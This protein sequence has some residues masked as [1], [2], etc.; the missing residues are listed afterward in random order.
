MGVTFSLLRLIAWRRLKEEPFR[1]ALTLVG[2]AL[3]VAVFIA[4]K[5]A[6]ETS[7]RAFENSL[8]AISGKTQLEVSAGGLGVDEDL[9]LSL[10]ETKGVKRAT[11]VMQQHVWVRKADGTGSRWRRGTPAQGRAVLTLGLDLL[12]DNDFRGYEF[13]NKY[14]REEILSRIADPQGLFI[15]RGVADALGVGVGD[16]VELEAARRMRFR[17]R[18]V[19]KPEGM[20]KS[21]DGRLMV[22]DIGVAQE[23]FERFGRLD[24][25]D[26]I[27][28]DGGEIESIREKIRSILPPGAIVERPARRGRDVEK[29]LASFQLNLT[30]LSVISLLVGCF[31]IY[32]TMSASV[33]RRRGEIATLRSLGLTARGIVFLYGAEALCI[34][35]AGSCLGVAMG[36]FMAQGALSFISQTIR[37]LYA[38][39]E[40][41]HVLFGPRELFWGFGVGL[42]VS[43]VSGIFP[44]IAA[45][46]QSPHQGIV[47]RQGKVEVRPKVI[48]AFVAIA[49][50]TALIAYWLN[51]QALAW[52]TPWPG[53]LSAAAVILATALFSL[54]VVLLGSL[55]VRRLLGGAVNV[56][57]AAHGLG[58]HPHRN[59]VTLSS[60][61]IAVAMLVSLIIMI[62]SFRATVEIWTQQ[63]LRAD[64]YAAPASRFIKGSNANISEDVIKTIG[65]VSGVAAVGGFRAVRL[66]WRGE[67][68]TLAGGDFRVEAERSHKLFVEGD[69]K[70]TL[71]RARTR[72]EAIITETFSNLYG[73]KKGDLLRLP[74]PGGEVSVRIAG[75]YY[76]YT[77]DGGLVVVDRTFFKKH[78]GD[79]RLSAL[80]I[81]LSE[82]A[83]PEDVRKSLEEV[84]DPTMVLISNAGLKKRVSSIFDQTFAITYALEFIV[85]LV[86]LLGVATGLSSNIL[87]RV[88]E[89][90][91]LR[92]MGLNRKGIVSAIMG[93]AAILGVLSVLA[94]LA[95][96]VCL[97]T[98][99]IFVVNK[100]SF[101]W[102]IQ[103]IFAWK[104]MAAYLLVV[105]LASLAAS[106]LPARVAA[107]IP[108]R[109]A[110]S[111]E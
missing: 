53:Y 49:L 24:R 38:F 18:G 61:A 100:L 46:R 79:D 34:G 94:G 91:A 12:G 102:T 69:S 72:G 87:E 106:W 107:S 60:L 45:S 109:E 4:V 31:L 81:Y 71:T 11:P 93:E 26:L 35:L 55:V 8:A 66:P 9:I 83:R 111:E 14:S 101:G 54:P 40:V 41:R 48:A 6:N 68:I 97:A 52:G 89:I 44:A 62:E 98:I 56:W 21:M 30:V 84:L 27:P 50:F 90:G 16:F 19:L 1:L 22:M 3:G 43:L 95:S 32:N 37:N 7:T 29:M 99:L 65:G 88:H 70:E 36:V 51:L 47:E 74:A 85:V 58:R 39:L 64:F 2:V 23:V 92:A 20:A 77:T 96:G 104:G 80:A 75:V 67:R 105:V 78:W 17:V 57:L 25:I 82:N 73:V 15:A 42:G 5:M 59:A 10:R 86:A 28:E 33:L 103:Y 76:D 63:T 110:L 13:E 108:I